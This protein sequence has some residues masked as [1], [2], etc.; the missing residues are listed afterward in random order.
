SGGLANFFGSSAA[1]SNCTFAGNQAVGGA[2]AA[3][4]DGGTGFGGGV[5]ND[6]QS[7][8]EVHG[9]TVTG[10]AARGGAAG[11]GGASGLGE[12]GGLYLAPGGCACLDVFTQG[13]VTGNHASTSDDIFGTFTTCP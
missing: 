5:F 6:D 11:T 10:N 4:S 7:S 3:G 8:L 13:H 12:G 9:S 2:G 1:V